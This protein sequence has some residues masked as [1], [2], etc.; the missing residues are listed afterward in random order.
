MQNALALLMAGRTTL[1][2]AHRLSTIIN[3]DQIIVLEKGKI[4]GMGTHTELLA[5]HSLYKELAQQ[6]RTSDT[7][8]APGKLAEF[9][10]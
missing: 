10:A 5:N 3:A 7:G 1:V 9:N 2:I 4:T 8:A 6:Q